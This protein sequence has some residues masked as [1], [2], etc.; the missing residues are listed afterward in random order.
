MQ[1]FDLSRPRPLGP[2]DAAHAAIAL[3]EAL[4]VAHDA[5]RAKTRFAD[6]LRVLEAEAD[7][8]GSARAMLGLARALQMLGDTAARA[9]L[10]DAGLLYEDLGDDATARAIDRDLRA[11]EAEIE[12]SPRSFSSSHRI[13]LRSPD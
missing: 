12:E 6:A 4:L 7:L 11:L 9:A 10:E 13:A 1:H 5:H 3:G 8:P 2:N